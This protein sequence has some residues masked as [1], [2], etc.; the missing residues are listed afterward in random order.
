MLILGFG[1]AGRHA[2]QRTVDRPIRKPSR[3]RSRGGCLMAA[4]SRGSALAATTFTEAA[5]GAFLLGV[6]TGSGDVA[7][8]AAR[9]RI[10]KGVRPAPSWRPSTGCSPWAPFLDRS[11]APQVSRFTSECWRSCDRCRPRLCGRRRRLLAAVSPAPTGKHRRRD[12]THP[13]DGSTRD[14]PDASGTLRERRPRRVYVLALLSFT[15]VSR[16]GIRDGLE[17]SA[18]AAASERRRRRGDRLPSARS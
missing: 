9:S 3:L 18:R 8:N 5:I 13:D 4:R 17:Q 1:A 14:A 12:G 10:G 7:M 16:R 11:S 15:L 2:D 6:A